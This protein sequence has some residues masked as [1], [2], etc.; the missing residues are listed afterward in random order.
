MLEISKY[1]NDAGTGQERKVYRKLQTHNPSVI[2]RKNR[3][4]NHFQ[5]TGE[6]NPEFSHHQA[7]RSSSAEITR[8]SYRSVECRKESRHEMT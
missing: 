8:P 4:V 6:T 3:H 7:I 2:T 5:S 1:H